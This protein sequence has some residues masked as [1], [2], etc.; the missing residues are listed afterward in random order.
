MAGAGP[1]RCWETHVYGRK[2]NLPAV[3]ASV[4]TGRA[5]ALP[6]LSISSMCR[7]ARLAVTVWS[8]SP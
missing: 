3:F 2:D 7:R 4:A 5:T 8:A 6:H 1:R